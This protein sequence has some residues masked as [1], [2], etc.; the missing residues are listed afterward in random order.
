MFLLLLL[1]PVSTVLVLSLVVTGTLD[2][3]NQIK[4]QKMLVACGKEHRSIVLSNCL[5]PFPLKEKANKTTKTG[6]YKSKNLNLGTYC[7]SSY[8]PPNRA[9]L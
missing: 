7:L 9:F 6:D 8:W 3:G 2:P 5:F 4:M 1:F